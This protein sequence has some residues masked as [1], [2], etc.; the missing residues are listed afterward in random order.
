[1]NWHIVEGHW[2]RFKGRMQMS[3]GDLR[4]RPRD[5]T[6]GRRLEHAG[7]AQLSYGLAKDEADQQMKRFQVRIRQQDGKKLF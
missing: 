3:W 5:V 2:K 1:M 7:R 6:A 4:D